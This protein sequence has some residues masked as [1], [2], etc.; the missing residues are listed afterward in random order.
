MRIQV[1]VIVHKTAFYFL[2]SNDINKTLL[3]TL[4]SQ[5]KKFSSDAKKS[6]WWNSRDPFW[7]TIH[8]SLETNTARVRGLCLNHTVQ[9]DSRE[10]L[11]TSFRF[12]PTSEI[13]ENIQYGDSSVVKTDSQRSRFI[14][15]E[16]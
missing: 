6:L 4:I 1:T 9:K 11:G 3:L 14:P 8:R 15:R 12:G 7:K 16:A 10:V 5:R 2:N 13:L